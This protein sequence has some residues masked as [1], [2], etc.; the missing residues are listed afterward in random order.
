MASD[1]VSFTVNSTLIEGGINKPTLLSEVVVEHID[2]SVLDH[3]HS[4]KLHYLSYLCFVFSVIAWGL[5]LLA[6]GLRVMGTL[7]SHGEAV[8]E[9]LLTL[10]AEWNFSFSHVLREQIRGKG[11]L[12]TGMLSEAVN[13]D[14]LHESV[15]VSPFSF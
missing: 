5:T 15:N 8:G 13:P 6:H 9:K 1:R 4:G 14:K 10:L 12:L 11:S 7:H 2:P 3:I